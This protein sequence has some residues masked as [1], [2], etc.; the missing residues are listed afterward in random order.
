MIKV[1][2]SLVTVARGQFIGQVPL[3]SGIADEAKNWWR[4]YDPSRLWA[5]PVN[6]TARSEKLP[7][8]MR[9]AVDG[10][11]GLSNCS[12]ASL[13]QL[14]DVCE[15]YS[16]SLCSIIGGPSDW[17]A[18]QKCNAKVAFMSGS[19]IQ[20]FVL[21]QIWGGL[22]EAML[23]D[24]QNSSER[25]QS[26]VEGMPVE[27][28]NVTVKM[29]C[30]RM[31]GT[32]IATC[33]SN[34]SGRQVSG[35]LQIATSS[36]LVDGSA[37]PKG[38]QEVAF[39]TASSFARDPMALATVRDV[40]AHISCQAY[41][42]VCIHASA[43]PAEPGIVSVHFNI[44]LPVQSEQVVSP[45]SLHSLPLQD[46]TALFQRGVLEKGCKYRVEAKSLTIEGFAPLDGLAT[47]CVSGS[48]LLVLAGCFLAI[49]KSRCSKPQKSHSDCGEPFLHLPT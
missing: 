21:A 8:Q 39:A 7:W 25:L 15:D 2:V 5:H 6:V 16:T 20:L 4:A 3:L 19:L 12:L 33:A 35:S 9:S 43:V 17:D 28:Q 41:G 47:Y 24:M 45:R 13:Q 34:A 1:V 36:M 44:T 42:L 10:L 40:I 30:P 32:C 27:L 38:E 18:P 37:E 26:L 31:C 29:A 46:L 11:A 23:K 14:G 22:S 48:F 49:R